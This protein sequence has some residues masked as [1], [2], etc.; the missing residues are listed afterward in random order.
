M[1]SLIAGTKYR[2]DFEKKLK[3]LLKEVAKIPNSI[4]FIDEIHTI[5]GAGSVGGSAMDAS[6][7]LKPMLA[8]G[9]LRCIGAT[10]FSEF[11]NDFSKD[12]ALSR[13]FAK[14]DVN[15][16]NEAPLYKF[17][18]SNQ[19]GILGTENIKW[20]FT[21]FLVDKDGTIVDRYGSASSPESIEKDM[22]L[23]KQRN[24]EAVAL[25]DK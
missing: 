7:I 15:G 17:L 2:G 11:R 21:K 25:H 1:G 20:N 8:N 12:K 3:S 14:V 10:T 4:L 13:R 18:K 22:E 9:K 19:K 23:K 5:V 6:N 24:K 16:E